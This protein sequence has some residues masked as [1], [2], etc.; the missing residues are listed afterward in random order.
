MY[1]VPDYIIDVVALIGETDYKKLEYS[2]MNL[3]DIQRR[4][5]IGV[6]KFGHFTHL[7]SLKNLIEVTFLAIAFMATS[8]ARLCTGSS[9]P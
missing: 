6:N 7:F 4:R 1:Q 5:L 3:R 8:T 9:L 2:T